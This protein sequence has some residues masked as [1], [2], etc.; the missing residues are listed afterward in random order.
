MENIQLFKHQQA[1]LDDTE[2]Q[3]ASDA[4]ALIRPGQVLRVPV[5]VE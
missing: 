5:G 2:I 3:Q 4:T 1:A